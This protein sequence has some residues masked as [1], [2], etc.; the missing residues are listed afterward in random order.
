MTEKLGLK[1]F[2]LVV[3]A[4]LLAVNCAEDGTAPDTN[5]PPNTFITNYQIDIAPDSATGYMVNISWSG[6]DVDGAIFW[7]EWRVKKY[8]PADLADS[9]LIWYVDDG[10]GGI[11]TLDLTNDWQPTNTQGMQIKLDYAT[12]DTRYFLQVRA[13]DNDRAYDPTPATDTISIDRIRD[14]NYAPNTEIVQGPLDGERTTTGIHFIVRGLDIDGAVDTIEYKLDTDTVWTK[15]GT[16]LYTST[17]TI[18][19]LNVAAGARTVSFRAIDNFRKTDPTPVTRSII[20]D[21]TLVPDLTIVSGPIPNAY[22]YLP[23]GG[24]TLDL[25][26]TWSGSGAWYYSTL[27]FRYAVDDTT[28]WSAW[29]SASTATLEGLT[30]TNHD[31]YVQAK[32]LGGGISLYHTQFAVGPFVGDQGILVFNGIHEASYGAS[33]HDFWNGVD[34]FGHE[35][36]FWDAFGGEDYSNTPVLDTTYIGSGVLPGTVLGNYS[37][38]VMIVNNYQGDLEVYAAMVPLIYSYL[39]AGGNVFLGCRA[40]SNFITSDLLTYTHLLPAPDT[41]D[42]IQ[43]ELLP[44]ITA[45]VEGLVDMAGIGSINISDLP[46]IP[47]DPEVTVIFNSASFPEAAVG[48]YVNPEVGG[49]YVYVAGRPYRYNT[50]AYKANVDYILT[51]YFGEE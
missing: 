43:V 14:Y 38:M 8:N 41:W 29:N 23:A 34:G 4:L 21:P 15:A 48:I 36:D 6:N 7:Y 1:V 46:A 24:S 2:G 28:T 44:G 39:N 13:Q 17:L 22:Y 45:A 10:D 33:F 26:A 31:F 27:L 50:A 49:K 5:L 12:F 37:S 30:A 25:A 18:D 11:D 32:D 47:T 3:V 40:G 19:I 16:D 51:N 35:I 42:Q 9:T 20:V